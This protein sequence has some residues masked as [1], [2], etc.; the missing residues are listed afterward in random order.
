MQKIH[1]SNIFEVFTAAVFHPSLCQD[2]K[3]QYQRKVPEF[4]LINLVE[5]KNT[6]VLRKKGGDFFD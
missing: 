4:H 2:L 1:I 5:K 6:N 3:R